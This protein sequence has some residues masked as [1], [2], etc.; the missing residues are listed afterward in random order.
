MYVILKEEKREFKNKYPSYIE[1][2]D[3]L[4]Q[5]SFIS[6]NANLEFF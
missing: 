1:Q 2:T 4:I 5:H 6:F 3:S